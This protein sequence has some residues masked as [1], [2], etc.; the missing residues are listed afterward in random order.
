MRTRTRGISSALDSF[1]S[2]VDSAKRTEAVTEGVIYLKTHYRSDGSPYD[3]G[4]RSWDVLQHYTPKGVPRSQP[5]YARAGPAL[6]LETATEIETVLMQRA[7]I[8]EN[9]RLE[10]RRMRAHDYLV[11][12]GLRNWGESATDIRMLDQPSE[13][14]TARGILDMHA[15]ILGNSRNVLVY[16]RP[17][18]NPALRRASVPILQLQPDYA[19]EA[20]VLYSMWSRMFEQCRSKLA[21]FDG[22][23]ARSLQD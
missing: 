6:D 14:A 19:E 18:G 7:G 5:L 22:K 15:Q 23:V 10:M 20:R 12:E 1:Y 21:K 17:S 13:L 9:L 11:Q 8:P 16:T 3:S 4:P 2:A